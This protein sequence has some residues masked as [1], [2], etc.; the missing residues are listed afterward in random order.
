NSSTKKGASVSLTI[1]KG[2]DLISV[3]SVTT[4]TETEAF[5]TLQTAGFNPQALPS[6]FNKDVASGTVFKQT[7]EGGTQAAKGSTVSYVVS[8]GT[9]LVQVPD[10]TGKSQSSATSALEKAGFKVSVRESTS[11]KTDKGSVMSQNPQ[12]GVSIAKGSTVAIT[13]ASGPAT[14]KVPAVV[15]DLEALAKT[16]LTEA[17][18]HVTVLVAESGSGTGKVITQDP[19]GST[20]ANIGSTVTITIDGPVV[21]PTP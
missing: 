18:F 10:V 6:E 17:G 13:V 8:R 9:E 15:G 2:P 20:K 19:A 5:K 3:P 11:D 1:S 14:A 16:K 4:M 7:P 12:S 21:P